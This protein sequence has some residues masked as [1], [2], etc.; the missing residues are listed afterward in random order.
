[1]K[2][3][4]KIVIFQGDPGTGDLTFDE[5]RARWETGLKAIPQA[6]EYRMI[7]THR[8]M[9]PEDYWREIGDADAA[10]GVWI[11]KGLMTEENYASHPRLRYLSTLSHGFEEFDRALTRAYGL[12]VTNTVYGGHT[13][14]QYAIAL[15]L[16][17][18]HNIPAH[19]QYAKEGYWAAK[20][21]GIPAPFMKTFTRQIELYGKTFG[22]IGLGSIGLPAAEMA[23]GL[24]MKALA[25]SR[26]KKAGPQYRF[27]EQV[28][29]DELLARSD[30]ISLHC[31]YSAENDK[32]IN[33]ETIAKMKDGVILINTAR[34]G[35]IDEEA[36]YEALMSRKIYRAGLDVL[37]EEP[38]KEK[39]PLLSCPY[40]DITAHIAWVPKESRLRA[41]D[42]ALH[43]YRCW[44]EGRP[45]SVIN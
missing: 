23:R 5:L 35:L 17:I 38:P 21:E 29:F 4:Q 22:V 2:E 34:G 44:L 13:I 7:K 39:T 1:M 9:G 8:G 15:L 18:C 33:R 20:E 24:G 28:S 30:V 37:R 36:L 32:M 14:A 6:A 40:A 10:L 42:L 41:V 16:N 11:T 27:I 19:V 45:E 43:N 26:R 25:Y 3:K 12:T 31:P